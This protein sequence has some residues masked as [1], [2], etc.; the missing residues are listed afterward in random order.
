MF[1]LVPMV[2]IVPVPAMVPL[3][4]V[5]AMQTVSPVMQA[6]SPMM[7]TVS[8]MVQTVPNLQPSQ[9]SDLGQLVSQLK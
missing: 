6:V 8:S 4:T 1:G 5:P 3:V 7:Q 2:V 9:F